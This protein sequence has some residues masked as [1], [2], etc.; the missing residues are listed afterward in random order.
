MYSEVCLHH[1]VYFTD[2]VAFHTMLALSEGGDLSARDIKKQ[3]DEWAEE[4]NQKPVSSQKIGA[5]IKDRLEPTYVAVCGAD[6]PW[7]HGYHRH[8]RKV[9]VYRLTEA[10][11]C[12]V[13]RYRYW[14]E[15]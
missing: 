12:Y 1:M 7:K 11:R 2:Y 10:G 9:N 6:Y 8:N 5:T 15:R 4:D 14:W 13:E 3:M